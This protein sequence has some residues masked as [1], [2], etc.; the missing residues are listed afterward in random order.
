M[1][2]ETEWRCKIC[3]ICDFHKI[4]SRESRQCSPFTISKVKKNKAIVIF[5]FKTIFHI[6]TNIALVIQQEVTGL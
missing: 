5:L 4:L 3:H 6:F 2:T 1:S